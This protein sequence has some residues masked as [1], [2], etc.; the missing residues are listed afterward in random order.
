M[1]THS[2]IQKFVQRYHGF[3]PKPDWINH[4]K[5]VWGLPT[6]QPA[7]RAGRGRRVVPLLLQKREMIEQSLR[8][9]GSK[10]SSAGTP[11][12]HWERFTPTERRP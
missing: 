5:V 9:F 4:V 7:N 12:T 2:E 8:H 3:I 11:R 10:P 6:R 1:P